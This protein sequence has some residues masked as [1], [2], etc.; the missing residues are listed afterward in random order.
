MRRRRA[1]GASLTEVMLSMGVALV[2]MLALFRVLAASVS[3]S[4]TASHLTQA[5]LR[6]ATLVETMRLA[7]RD[8]MRCLAATASARWSSCGAMFALQSPDRGGQPYK[9][10]ASSAVTIT[11][12]AF[13]LFVVVGFDDP[14]GYHTVALRS[15]VYP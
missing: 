3:G 1:R 11:G 2:G 8:T 10:D 4:A 5:E 14:G 6:A 15:G 7:P 13:D 12:G 9:L